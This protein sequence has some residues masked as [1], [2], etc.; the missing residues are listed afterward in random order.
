MP[1]HPLAPLTIVHVVLPTGVGGMQRVVEALAVGLHRRGHRVA[2]AGVI[3]APASPETSLLTALRA[4][5]VAVHTVQTSP[6]GYLSERAAFGNLCRSLRP[7][8]VH[9][10]GYRPDVVDA[11]VARK[12]GVGVVT[13]VHGFTGGDWKNRIYERLQL[14]AFRRFDAVVA[15][16]RPLAELLAARGTPRDRIHVVPN[17]WGPRGA[18]APRAE[19]RRALGVPADGVCIGWVGR[20]TREKGADVLVRAIASLGEPTLTAALVGDGPELERVRAAAAELGV[21]DRVLWTGVIPDA[22]RF[23]RAFDVFVLSS[24]SEGTPIVLFEAMAASVPIVATAVG[25]VPDV[26]RDSEAVLVPPE[27]PLALAQAIRRVAEDPRQAEVR[28]HAAQ[29]RLASA[30]AEGPWLDRYEA[31]YRAV[32]VRPGSRETNA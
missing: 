26:V 16:S 29:Q 30:F 7:D 17:A 4:A 15:V 12:L 5:G 28:A 20:F 21:A 13:T 23:M 11:A 32:L 22:G 14:R 27:D 2:V 25:G 24:R 19:A 9:T 6:R 3:P 8:I 1:N 10:H 18:I 31:V